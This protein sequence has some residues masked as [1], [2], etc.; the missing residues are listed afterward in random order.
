MR[1]ADSVGSPPPCGEGLGVG[2]V[3]CGNAVPDCTTP[4]PTPPPQGGR[5]QTEFAA[6]FGTKL[7][8]TAGAAA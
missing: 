4:L 6:L 7:T 8:E 1:A 5:E 3:R 2:V